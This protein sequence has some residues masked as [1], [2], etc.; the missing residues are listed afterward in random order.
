[1]IDPLPQV[2]L[3][4]PHAEEARTVPLRTSNRKGDLG[5]AIIGLAIPGKSIGHHHHPLGTSV[6]RSHQH[7]SRGQFGPLLIEADETRG[8]RCAGVLCVRS[9]KNLLGLVIQ[10]AKSIGLDSIGDDCKQQVPRQVIGRQ[11]LKHALPS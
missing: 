1:M 11:S 2:D 5:E 4:I 7:S 3:L 10:V 8:H 6:P 9:I